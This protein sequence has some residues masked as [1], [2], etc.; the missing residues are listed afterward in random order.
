MTSTTEAFTDTVA[1]MRSWIQVA[2]LDP[3]YQG[4]H[5]NVIYNAKD[6]ARA[7]LD[8]VERHAAA[9]QPEC[10]FILRRI[11][12]DLDGSR[13]VSVGAMRSALTEPVQTQTIRWEL[14]SEHLAIPDPSEEEEAQ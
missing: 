13:W 11:T 1:E 10:E 7:L 9:S 8:I 14:L 12:T 2:G 6:V 3:T 4:M 5:S